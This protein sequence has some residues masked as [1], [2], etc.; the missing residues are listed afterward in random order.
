MIGKMTVGGR[1]TAQ[2]FHLGTFILSAGAECRWYI[3]WLNLV[4]GF[5]EVRYRIALEL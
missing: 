5:Y 1:G 4:S 2:N 3:C